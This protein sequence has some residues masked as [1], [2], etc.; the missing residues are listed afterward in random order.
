[1][2]TTT[3][4]S[5][6]IR[7][8]YYEDYI[9]GGLSRRIYDQF[10]F[11][12]S[13]DAD[14]MQRGSSHIVN[15]LGRMTPGSTAISE[16]VDV[17]P[18]T[19]ADTTATVTPTSRGEAIQDSELLL[20]QS[21]TDYG[22]QRYTILGENMIET[23]E[24]LTIAS[25]LAGSV[26]YRAAARAALDAGTS[27]HRLSDSS[28]G[29]L[30]GLQ[31]GL[32][33]PMFPG[34]MGDS[35]GGGGTLAAVMHPD[36]YYDLVTGGNIVSIAQY[37]D[38][39]ILLN[40]EVGFIAP[41][42]IISSAWAKAFFGA[43]QDQTSNIATTLGAAATS[44]DT[45]ATVASGTNIED[46]RW[47]T[48]GTEETA[49]TFYPTN[50]RVRY[51]SGAD[52]V[53]LTFVGQG[54]NGG[55]KYDHANGVA[56]RNADS[57]YPVLCGGPQSVAKVYAREIGEFGDVVGPKEQGLLEQWVSLGWKYYGGFGVIAEPRLARG[58][59]SSSLDA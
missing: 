30:A 21:Y 16:T 40:R 45:T 56:V 6:A 44:L 42:R 46:G 10:C 37:Q 38:K 36:V 29:Q 51:V 47:L 23:L 34:I 25:A 3:N 54:D 1:M 17:S 14:K 13:E 39:N 52:G 41:Y 35:A 26:V 5:N 19:L 57:V 32:R 33:C 43:G 8:R 22:E 48:I 59:F 28:F 12:I 49:S 18:Q 58:E 20:L 15:F 2:S 24:A 50:E 27:G 4:L 11:P 55:L 53:T 31:E 7:A 9:M